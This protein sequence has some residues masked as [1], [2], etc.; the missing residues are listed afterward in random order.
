MSAGNDEVESL[1]KQLALLTAENDR[2]KDLL[3][4]NEP[5]EPVRAME[6]TL[7]GDETVD[8]LPEVDQGS[9]G[10][11]KV[12]LFQELFVGRSD[13]HA[14]RWENDRSGK[15]GWSPAVVGGWANSRKPNRQYVPLSAAAIQS[16]LAGEVHVGLYPL[17]K[18]DAC[19]ILACDFDG[20]TWALDA[21]AFLDAANLFGFSA[22]LERSRSGDGGHVWV[23]F[24]DLVAA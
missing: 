6:A 4:L 7:F 8:P 9:S 16:H 22:S 21:R 3:G 18:G 23:F 2:L 15:S 14:L 11:E 20:S 19:R 12:A 13:V 5:R 17:L 10:D 24:S 1:K